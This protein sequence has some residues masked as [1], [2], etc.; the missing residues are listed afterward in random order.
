M[1]SRM[2]TGWLAGTLQPVVTLAI[3][4][5]L[6][7]IWVWS[8]SSADGRGLCGAGQ[9]GRR[10]CGR[11]RA[12]SRFQRR[13]A[14]GCRGGLPALAGLDR[15][16]GLHVAFCL[17][18]TFVETAPHKQCHDLCQC[19]SRCFMHI[20]CMAMCTAR[21]AA[22]GKVQEM[23]SCSST[24]ALIADEPTSTRCRRTAV[25]ACPTLRSRRFG[26]SRMAAPRCGGSRE[27]RQRCRSRC[28]GD[29]SCA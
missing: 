4:E 3:A 25:R 15:L 1:S 10:D 23:Q 19:R 2:L 18:M 24:D 27:L 5:P 26:P 16:H 22:A 7:I 29:N 13:P 9:G 14:A 11:R 21:R 28:S 20:L 8:T 17:C 6:L 12:A